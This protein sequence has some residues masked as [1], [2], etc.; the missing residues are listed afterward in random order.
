MLSVLSVE[1]GEG[2]LWLSKEMA[3][4]AYFLN[5]RINSYCFKMLQSLSALK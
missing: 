2:L 3:F 4:F 5:L 1:K